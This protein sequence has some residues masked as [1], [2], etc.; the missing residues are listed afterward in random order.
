MSSSVAC[1][2]YWDVLRTALPLTFNAVNPSAAVIVSLIHASY[3]AV[4]TDMPHVIHMAVAGFT[5]V[6]YL[7]MAIINLLVVS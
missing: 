3:S 2:A 6:L 5:L 7:A 4:C 1:R